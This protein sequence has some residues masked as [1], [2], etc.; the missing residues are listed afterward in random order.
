[1]KTNDETFDTHRMLYG[2]TPNP[3]TE[4]LFILGAREKES[5]ADVCRRRMA[6]LGKKAGDLP[7]SWPKPT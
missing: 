2:T 3:V 1:M 4:A 7:A 6:E 5:L